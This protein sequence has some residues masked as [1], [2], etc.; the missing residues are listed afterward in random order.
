MEDTAFR[1]EEGFE[2]TKTIDEE[3]INTS[4]V[5]DEG[6]TDAE[7]GNLHA[8]KVIREAQERTS[9]LK[10]KTMGEMVGIVN[11]I[12]AKRGLQYAAAGELLCYAL[13][14]EDTDPERSQYFIIMMRDD[15]D[16]FFD[17]AMKE[18]ES[19]DIRVCP[20]YAPDGSMERIH[21]YIEI[22]RE[23]HGENGYASVSLRLRIEP[24]EILPEDEEKRKR[25]Y[26]TLTKNSRKLI[27]DSMA[28]HKGKGT[29]KLASAAVH[30]AYPKSFCMMTEK[31][32]GQAHYFHDLKDPVLCGRVEHAIFRP[33]RLDHIF[34]VQKCEFLGTQ[35]MIPACPD[36]FTVPV[37]EVY[38]EE[39]F[40]A[41]VEALRRF[42]ALCADNNLQYTVMGM[43]SS[44]ITHEGKCSE[45]NRFE[46]W[47]TGM[48][49]ADYEKAVRLLAEEK[50][51]ELSFVTHVIGYPQ[52]HSNHIG[53]I[54]KNR[55]PVDPWM[56]NDP[57]E[58]YPLDSVPDDY[59]EYHASMEI[60][61]KSY[62]RIRRLIRAETCRGYVKGQETT[63]TWKEYDLM[64]EERKNLAAA[65]DAHSDQPTRRVY[66][67]FQ[68]KQRIYLRD[69]I[70]PLV[71]RQFENIEVWG[72]AN[73][74]IWRAEKDNDYS[75]YITKERVEILKLLDKICEE[76]KVQYFAIATLLV[77]AVIYHDFVP[78]AG[79]RN[80]DVGLLRDDYEHL[81]RVLR[82]KAGEYG[83]QLNEF[84]DNKQRVPRRNKTLSWIGGDL[85]D[86]CIRILPFD[87]VPED[88]YLYQGFNDDLRLKLRDFNSLIKSHTYGGPVNHTLKK[89]PITREGLRLLRGG[90][91][92]PKGIPRVLY[93]T[94]YIATKDPVEE[95]RK[96][97]QLAQI[98]NDDER[99]DTYARV[100]LGRSKAIMGSELFPLQRHPFRDMMLPCPGDYSVWQPM[101]NDE[102]KRQVSCLQEADLILLQEFDR[103]CRELG[104]GYFVCGGTMLGYMRHQG[105]IPWDDDVD[106]AMLRSDYDRFLKEGGPLLKE[107][108]FLQT[109]ETDPNIPYLF[110]KIRMDDTE[111]ITSYNEMR[112]FHKG[113][114]LDMFPFDFLPDRP[115]RCQ[116]YI[117]EVLKLA[118]EHHRIANHQYAFPEDV[119]IPRNAKEKEYI[120][121][122]QA[123]LK[124]YWKKDLRE[125]QK[126][127]IDAATRYNADAKELGLTVV[128][129]FIPDF[130]YIDLSDLLPYQ[131]GLFEGVEVSVPKRPDVFLTMQY[132]DYMQL[133]PVHQQVAHR[134][135][136]WS[137]WT[138]SSEDVP[139]DGQPN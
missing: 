22:Y 92:N 39:R 112:D 36:E 67:I 12:C 105:F 62:R 3:E 131:R 54:L 134:L 28:R 48:L 64:Q 1:D 41:R 69:E 81:I 66:T 7:L 101:L 37:K 135:L 77:G 109:R 63:D 76:E 18:A 29:Q 113:V 50:D 93:R 30:T 114:C 139:G 136:R 23:S 90:K 47:L 49:R 116:D 95:A 132:G 35:L 45:E 65:A 89:N 107:R 127:Y 83:L 53:F 82:R 11:D 125:S 24:Y 59:E 51:P 108:F 58:L 55:R 25:F 43:L 103:V 73:P 14:G 38:D 74:W 52:A 8:Q 34:P 27:A 80:F 60:A 68:N 98:F 118:K 100:S 124:R 75:E 44:D 126:A 86:I 19:L 33:H 16:A 104:V 96:L 4:Q 10:E 13:T 137:T 32:R 102:L 129:S 42:D 71:R 87:K 9:L 21:S 2:T 122:K 110:S 26:E 121:K 119:A 130:T 40:A 133:P 128:A 120:H 70:F 61:I 106:V 57:I 91:L 111:Y 46:V 5:L 94:K 88:F 72:P 56:P 117:S 79:G 115:E 138:A 123:E 15:Y 6:G 20:L 31:Y 17:A 99:T 97:D 78:E 85:S 84:V